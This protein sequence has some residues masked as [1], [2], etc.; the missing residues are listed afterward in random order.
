MSRS[1]RMIKRILKQL[2][3][4]FLLLIPLAA[5]LMLFHPTFNHAPAGEPCPACRLCPACEGLW[6]PTFLLLYLVLLAAFLVRGKRLSA[7]VSL[8]AALYILLVRS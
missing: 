8:L 5:A 4:N 2:F 7:V 1:L 3:F 6:G